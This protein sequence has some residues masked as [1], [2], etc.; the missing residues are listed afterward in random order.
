[1]VP[2]VVRALKGRE[3]DREREVDLEVDQARDLVVEVDQ[4]R[5]LV[6]DQVVKVVK[7]EVDQALGHDHRRRAR[8]ATHLL[9]ALQSPR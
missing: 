9:R 7:A 6:V 8:K 2:E 3:V 4:A 1:M 5:D